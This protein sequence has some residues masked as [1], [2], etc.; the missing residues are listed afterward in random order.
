MQRHHQPVG[1]GKT[2][3]VVIAIIMVTF[4]LIFLILRPG[5]S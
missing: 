1:A 2:L 5:H 4:L 3:F